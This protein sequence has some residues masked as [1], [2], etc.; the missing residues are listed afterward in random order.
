MW[1]TYLITFFLGCLTGITLMAL[2]AANGRDNDEHY[3]RPSGA[4]APS[5]DTAGAEDRGSDGHI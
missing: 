4:D 1:W 5:A 3:E 2:M